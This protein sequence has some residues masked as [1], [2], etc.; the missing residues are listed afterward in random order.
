MY[1][2][3]IKKCMAATVVMSNKAPAAHIKP[4]NIIKTYMKCMHILQAACCCCVVLLIFFQTRPDAAMRLVDCPHLRSTYGR[5]Q[6]NCVVP[7]HLCV[8]YS[9]LTT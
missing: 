5:I 2:Y 4:P 9:R 1:Y 8:A 3:Y 7:K 6:Y